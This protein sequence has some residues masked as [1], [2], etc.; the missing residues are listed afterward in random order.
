MRLAAGFLLLLGATAQAQVAEMGRA[1]CAQWL[2]LPAEDGRHVATWLHGYFAGAAHR[3][4]LDIGKLEAAVEG[5]RPLCT[6][7]PALPLLGGEVRALFLGPAQPP[8]PAPTA[9]P[10]PAP[11]QPAAPAPDRPTP[12]R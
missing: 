6:R 2:T 12:L 7:E 9:A 11:E 1:T 4:A 10:V 5:L 3:T 8:A